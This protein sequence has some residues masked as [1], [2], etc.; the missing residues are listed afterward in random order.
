MTIHRNYGKYNVTESYKCYGLII[1]CL[2]FLFNFNNVN[3]ILVVADRSKYLN[4]WFT[5]DAFSS[6]KLNKR[7]CFH[8]SITY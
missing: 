3:F 6:T 4:S 2:Y 1:R 8:N 7:I 5:F